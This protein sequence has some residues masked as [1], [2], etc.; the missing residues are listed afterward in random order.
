[1]PAPPGNPV[2]QQH[3]S[4]GLANGSTHL[5]KPPCWPRL[6][7]NESRCS[8]RLDRG[9]VP[10]ERARGGSIFC[11]H[12]RRSEVLARGEKQEKEKKLKKKKRKEKGRFVVACERSVL[13]CK[14]MAT[15]P[16]T[17]RK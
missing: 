14:S 2:S 10:G 7:G 3:L 6:T 16:K 8:H 13:L 12:R 5:Q 4:P 1:M 15:I 9:Y 11:R 17:R